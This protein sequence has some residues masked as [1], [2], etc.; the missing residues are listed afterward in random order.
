MRSLGWGWNSSGLINTVM[1]FN[2]IGIN[3]TFTKAILLP[4]CHQAVN[5]QRL[6][7]DV[8]TAVCLSGFSDVAFLSV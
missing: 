5:L 2:W 1:L 8:W 7:Y 6:L 3:G 4:E